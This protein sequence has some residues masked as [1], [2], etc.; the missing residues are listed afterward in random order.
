MGLKSVTVRQLV[1]LGFG[2]K[3]QSLNHYCLASEYCEKPTSDL[4][5]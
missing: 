1:S 2:D 5:F 4:C 3:E